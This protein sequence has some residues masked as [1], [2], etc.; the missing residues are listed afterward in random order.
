MLCLFK[1]LT[2][3]VTVIVFRYECCVCVA[4]F[5]AGHIVWLYGLLGYT[6][7]RLFRRLLGLVRLVTSGYSTC[8]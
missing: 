1:E 5:V 3:L 8:L 2:Y 7:L 6:E 4:R